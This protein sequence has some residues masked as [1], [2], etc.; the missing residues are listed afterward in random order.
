MPTDR[1][2]TKPP[3]LPWGRSFIRTVAFTAMLCASVAAVG[4]EL[5]GKWILDVQ[6]PGHSVVAT[7]EV[8][9]TDVPASACMSGRWKVVKV[10][11]TNTR[12]AGFFPVTDPLSYQVESGKLTIGSN[13]V[14]DGYL[15][16]QGPL[17]KASMK[18]DYFSLGLGG[19]SPLGY[20]TMRPAK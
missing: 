4:G 15:W 10:L 13:G 5:P 20:F 11:S 3:G 12:D 16:L 1:L 17:G 8:E 6:D 14:C 18:G 9:F 19:S 7:L 2:G